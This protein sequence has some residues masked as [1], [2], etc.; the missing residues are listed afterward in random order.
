MK[1]AAVW[2]WNIRP[3]THKGAKPLSDALHAQIA[4]RVDI[5]FHAHDLSLVVSRICNVRGHGGLRAL[6][7]RT[8]EGVSHE[9]VNTTVGI[10]AA[11]A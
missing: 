3:L 2:H 8:R 11:K 5:F 1:A 6:L 4:S 10:K 9:P 7:A